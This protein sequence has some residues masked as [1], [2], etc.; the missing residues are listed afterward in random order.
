M[1]TINFSFWPDE[2]DHYDVSW[3][4][5]AYTGYFAACAAVNKAIA[6]GIPVLS[7]EWMKN[8]GR[9]EI[10]RI[11]KSD[12]GHSIPLLD[13]RVKAIND[14]GKVLLEKFDGQFYNCVIKSEKSA[15]TLLKLIV[16]NFVS[17][18]D[19]AE[20]NGQKVSL[21]KR[22]QILVADVYGSLQG[23]DDAGNFKDITTITMF[24]D[25]RVPQALAYLGALDYSE[26]LLSQLGEGKRL[27]NGSKAEVELRGASIAVCD[28]IVAKMNELRETDP[29]FSDVCEVNAMEV[30]VYVWGYRR[31]YAADVEKK[32][33]FHRTRCIYY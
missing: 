12:S 33:P 17:F 6:A 2:G 13:D 20:F 10:D 21:L 7:A 23:H 24:A 8:V 5:K 18:R 32:V 11:F 29:R 26:E 9:E 25:Y 3:G 16:E 27:E 19:F 1:D 30:D 28:E 4:G 14:S 15:Q 31:L 22:A